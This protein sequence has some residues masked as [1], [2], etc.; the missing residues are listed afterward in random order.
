MYVYMKA[1]YYGKRKPQR[2]YPDI[3]QFQGDDLFYFPMGTAE[4]YGLYTRSNHTRFYD[5]I[6]ALAEHG[7]IEVVSNG[8]T[9]KAK[10]IYRYSDKWR[11]WNDSS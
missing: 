9:H 11:L 8:K 6:K 10:S 1:Q 3:E 5:D 2:D 7:F 4:K